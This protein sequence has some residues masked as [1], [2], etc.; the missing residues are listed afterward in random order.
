MTIEKITSSLCL[1]LVNF[2]VMRYLTQKRL[3]K[4]GNLPFPPLLRETQKCFQVPRFFPFET[5][6][7]SPKR[8]PEIFLSA[9]IVSSYRFFLVVFPTFFFS[10]GTIRS[11][12]PPPSSS[13]R[14]TR[15]FSKSQT[16]M[17]VFGIIFF[18]IFPRYRD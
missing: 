1:I 7:P 14:E 3:Y 9:K 15:Y 12:S 13:L 2:K 4:M 5:P 8:N 16:L 18:K 6:P 10:T 11:V 17:S